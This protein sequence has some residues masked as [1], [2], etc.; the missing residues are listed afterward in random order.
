MV[1]KHRHGNVWAVA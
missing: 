1:I